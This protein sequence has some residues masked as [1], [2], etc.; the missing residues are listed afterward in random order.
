M[1][2]AVSI[3]IFKNRGWKYDN[4]VARVSTKGQEK[5]GNSLEEQEKNLLEKGCQ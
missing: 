5:N 3:L 1:Y 4:W 2:R